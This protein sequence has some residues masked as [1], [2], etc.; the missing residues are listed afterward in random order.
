MP[1]K[2]GYVLD[3]HNE[4]VWVDHLLLLIKNP[5]ESDIMGKTGFQEFETKY[6]QDVMFDRIIKMYEEV[7]KSE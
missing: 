2:T 4:K 3:P 6:N 1:E 5:N 7:I